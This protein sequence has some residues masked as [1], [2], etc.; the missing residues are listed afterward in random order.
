MQASI[1]RN[2]FSTFPGVFRPLS[3][4]AER[5]STSRLVPQPFSQMLSTDT[6]LQLQDI[7]DRISRHEEISLK[8]ISLIQKWSDHNRHAY[9]ILQKARRRAISGEPEPGSLDELIDGMNLGFADPSSH[10]VGP[11][12]PDDLANFFRAPPWL[13]HD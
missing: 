4:D 13:R 10:L 12:S 11:Q 6:R 2:L 9:E 8:E 7:A 3:T 5:S 1:R